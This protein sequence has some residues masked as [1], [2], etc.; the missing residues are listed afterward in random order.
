MPLIVLNDTVTYDNHDCNEYMISYVNSKWVVV[1]KSYTK[2]LFHCTDHDST[3][4]NVVK[5][6][7][8][9]MIFYT[10]HAV[11]MFIYNIIESFFIRL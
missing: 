5:D 7:F 6:K 9:T 10:T 1:C 3:V 8:K 2:L 4:S 11:T